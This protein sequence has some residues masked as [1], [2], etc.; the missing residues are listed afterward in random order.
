MPTVGGDLKAGVVGPF[1]RAA[2]L[3]DKGESLGFFVTVA[4]PPT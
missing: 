4:R 2:V 3:A 1:G